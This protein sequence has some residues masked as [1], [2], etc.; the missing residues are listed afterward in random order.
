MCLIWPSATTVGGEC[1]PSARRLIWPRCSSTVLSR[2][3]EGASIQLKVVLA[4][5]AA[6]RRCWESTTSPLARFSCVACAHSMPLS[7]A[8][9]NKLLEKCD[10]VAS[11]AAPLPLQCMMNM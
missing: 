8:P 6:V 4:Q 1:W 2:G 7:H 9:F 10:P 11:A 3:R 5:A